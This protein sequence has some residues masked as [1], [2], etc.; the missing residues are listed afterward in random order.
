MKVA[1]KWW[2]KAVCV[3]LI[4]VKNLHEKL[5]QKTWYHELH[6]YKHGNFF[7]W[8]FLRQQICHLSLQNWILGYL[9]EKETFAHDYV[10]GYKL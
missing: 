4:N 3:V 6:H 1:T 9:Y 5:Q 8:E 10:Y 2:E 7:I